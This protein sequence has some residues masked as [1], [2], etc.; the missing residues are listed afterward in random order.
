MNNDM[1]F[2]TKK[3][4]RKYFLEKRLAIS[5][6]SKKHSDSCLFRAIARM[7]EYT[8]ADTLL[9]YSPIKGEP[10]LS[11]LALLALLEKKKVA[12]PISDPETLTLT[13]K[14]VKRPLKLHEG[15][16]GILQPY[17]KARNVRIT[18]KT[19]CIVPALSFD[20]RGHRLGYGKGYYDRFLAD[21]KGISLGAVYD[22]M[23]TRRLP[24]DDTDVPVDIVITETGVLYANEILKKER[25]KH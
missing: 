18:Q 8:N 13:F 10:D 16:Y 1:N 24:A 6:T 23:L 17:D 9:I 20:L 4:A 5:E 21:F 11:A 14:R 7:P 22:D 19:L 12:F 2:A 3:E 15:P 25:G